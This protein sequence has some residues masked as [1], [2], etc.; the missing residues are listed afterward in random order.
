MGPRPRTAV[1][2]GGSIL[3]HRGGGADVCP[4]ST[5]LRRVIESGDYYVDP[6]AVADAMLRRARAYARMPLAPS[7]VLVPADLFEDAAL[8][9]DKLQTLAFEDCA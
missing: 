9:P 7:K 3:I 2:A 1:Q 4:M 5:I 6:D 8:G